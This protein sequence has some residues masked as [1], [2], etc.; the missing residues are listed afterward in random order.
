MFSFFKSKS[1][2]QK[3]EERYKKLLEE[4]YKLSTVN[5]KLSDE[6]AFE[7]DQILKQIESLD[8]QQ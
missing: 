7:A 4:S 6:K 5:R 3:L 2:K 8:K 1:Q